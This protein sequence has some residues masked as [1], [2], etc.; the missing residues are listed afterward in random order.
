M[1][2]KR[3]NFAVFLIML[4]VVIVFAFSYNAYVTRTVADNAHNYSQI[5]QGYNMEIIE[6]VTAEESLDNWSSI[7]E[8]YED[9]IVVIENGNDEEVVRS[10]GRTWS[11]FDIKVQT[12]FEYQGQPYVIKSSVY[13]FR[14]YIK[15]VR[16]LVRFV[17]I[18]FII[19]LAAL[20]LLFLA[21]YSVM[22]RPY[23]NVYRAIE[24][25]DKTG[26]LKEIKI[27]GYAGSVYKRFVSLTEN[28]EKEQ[29]NQRR[30]IASISHDIKT[31]LTSIMGY[32]EQLQKEGISK[33]R[34]TRY[35]RI[36][37]AKSEDISRLINEFDDYLSYNN[38][39]ELNAETFTLEQIKNNITDDFAYELENGGIDF[40][41]HLEGD[42]KA[43]VSLDK[44]KSR[45]VI[46]N[47]FSNSVKH[48]SGDRKELQ[49][50]LRSE[51]EKVY[52][53]IDD[54]GEG[55]PE[56]KLDV[57]FEP[58]YT[59]DAGRKVAGLGLAICREITELHGGRIYAE[60]SRLGG[61]R[62]CIELERL[63]QM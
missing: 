54:S 21:V 10:I 53:I 56:D 6:K 41:I 26:K 59:S 63:R 60:K 52:I 42:A 14:D 20:V 7:I 38:K 35:L 44:D 2:S 4:S 46:G 40:G 22:L 61:L 12:T 58:L 43:L 34:Q 29:E 36:V 23:R 15:D 57:I 27:K 8:Q 18:E 33:E 3:S 51:K 49:V 32:T 62:V 9:V 48:L 55:V 13:I 31:P 39:R 16:V 17:F 47:I 45:R 1:G 5:L 11:V 24:E 28:L 25:Y 19:G 37:Y 30:I 50:T